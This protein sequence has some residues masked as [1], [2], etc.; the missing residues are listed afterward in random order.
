MWNRD[1]AGK[2]P[3]PRIRSMLP[4]VLLALSALSII[5]GIRALLVFDNTAGE[6]KAVPVEW[7]SSSVVKRPANR[8]ELLVFVHPYCSCTFASVA[9]LAQ[10]AARQKPGVASPVID[11]LFYRPRNSKWAPNSLWAKAQQLQG[12]HAQWDDDGREA[13]RFGA[14]T[15][16]YALLYSSKG[17][18]LFNGGVTGSRGHEGENYGIAQLAASLDSG[19]RAHKASL[20][21]GCALGENSL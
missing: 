9:E 15:S 20:V 16:G 14:R 6:V 8:P 10:L 17:E 4:V 19:R 5:P 2:L 11:F 3:A 7:P 13:R 12:A 21:F 18:L 1:S